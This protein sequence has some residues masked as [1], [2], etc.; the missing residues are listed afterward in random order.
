M[1]ISELVVNREV[2]GKCLTNA[3]IIAGL[4]L[5]GIGISHVRDQLYF[6]KGKGKNNEENERTSYNTCIMGYLQ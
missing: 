3:H 2:T 5:R 6:R 1:H 4:I